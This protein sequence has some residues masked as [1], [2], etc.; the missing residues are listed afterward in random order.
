MFS[1]CSGPCDTCKT[2]Y[3]GGC[4]AGHGD[5]DYVHADLDWIKQ[6]EARERAE[7]EMSAANKKL[8]ELTEP[9]TE[10]EIAELVCALRGFP[11][12][13]DVANRLAFQ[14]DRLVTEVKQLRR[15]ELAYH[16]LGKVP[17]E[18][19]DFLMSLID[20]GE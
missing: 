15:F 7:F 4:L 20:K 5:N 19:M 14:R 18:T 1:D 2:H 6:H 9:L 10:T 17:R 12:L 8:K 16:R 11:D 13:A 3:T